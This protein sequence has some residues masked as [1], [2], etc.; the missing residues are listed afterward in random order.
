MGS[1][2]RI[3]SAGVSVD[4]PARQGPENTP[5]QG[6]P[7]DKKQIF[8]DLA[9]S[10]K[11]AARMRL[12]A[13]TKESLL[14]A[15]SE[16]TA[17]AEGQINQTST[18][19]LQLHLQGKGPNIACRKGC[20]YCCR[21][22]VPATVPEILQL[23]AHINETFSEA[24]RG[25]L[26]LRLE[27]YRMQSDAYRRQ[28]AAR[29]PIQCPILVDHSCSAHKGRP[30]ICRGVNSMDVNACIKGLENW[31]QKTNIPL[32]GR[33]LYT[34]LAV[35]RGL[36]DAMEF[37]GIPDYLVEMPLALEIALKDPE[38]ADKWL[39]GKDVFNSA[40]HDSESTAKITLTGN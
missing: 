3:K 37:C 25:A 20:D 4:G 14:L 22:V 30:L 8:D 18:K 31:G 27:E 10:V 11:L 19:I 32:V 40:L 9:A 1:S 17:I 26:L 28:G 33:Q 39:A 5:W 29:P 7:P 13:K 15:V 12:K 36:R 21:V 2:K 38:A 23:A 34:A 35:R 6:L 24:D 16:G